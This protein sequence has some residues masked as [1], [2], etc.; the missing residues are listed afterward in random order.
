MF[1][2]KYRFIICFIFAV[3]AARFALAAPCYGTK[4]PGCG[5]VFAGTQTHNIFK[6]YL[7]DE[8][9]KIRSLQHFL[10]IS[11]GVWDWLSIDLKGGAGY[12]KQHPLGSDEIDYPTSFAG[13]YGVRVKLYDKERLKAVFGFHHI[14]VHPYSVDV[15]GVENKAVLDD[16]QVSLL[17]SYDMLGVTPYLGTKWSRLDYIHWVEEDRERRMSDLTKSIGLVCGLDIPIGEKI[18]I[19][20]EGHFFDEEAAS[21]ALNYKF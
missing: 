21:L 1:Y 7:E 8:Y 3:T 10:Q 20:L 16:W 11:C 6:R 4:M 17:A 14:S 2:G 13:G 5:E 9:G 19:N 12:I 15:N 18:W